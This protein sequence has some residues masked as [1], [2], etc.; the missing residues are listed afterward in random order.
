MALNFVLGLLISASLNQL[1]SMV[2]TQQLIVMM[3][4]FKVTLPANAGMFFSQMM[5]IAAFEV[6][7]TKPYLDA[8]LHL[9]PTDPVNSNFEA[10]G[11]ESRYFLHNLGTLALGYVFF[12]LSV[13]F[14]SL[15]RK[16][17][18]PNVKYFGETLQTSLFW[19]SLIELTT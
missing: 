6:I 10:I 3:P 15:C 18:Y 19:G 2:N 14:A 8:M 13:A 7:D 11:L 16:S 1:L 4:L 12:L 17:S 5:T 9:P